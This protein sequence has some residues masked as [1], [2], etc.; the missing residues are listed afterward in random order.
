VVLSQKFDLAWDVAQ[1]LARN[2]GTRAA[3]VLAYAEPDRVKGSRS[4]LYKH[5]PRLYEGAAATTGYPYLEAEIRYAI[6]HEFAVKPADILGR[7]TRL[8]YLNSTAAKLA[9]PKVV[10]IMG[11]QLGWDEARR[12]REH[13]M[14]EELLAKDFAGPAPN[15]KG[16]TLRAACT[17]DVKDIFDKIDIKHRGVLSK[18]GIGKAADELG[19]PLTGSELHQAMTE[20]DSNHREEVS[21][22]EFLAWWNSS[23]KSNDVQRK[24]FLGVRGE[25]K[26]STVAE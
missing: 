16:A 2:Y 1:H 24:I 14:A 7:R 22:P 15:K 21:F 25:A 9:L 12:L 11:D 26:W 5:Y 17:A 8:A 4:G 19:F 13:E 6:D 10:E 18:E 20:M 3:E 23:S